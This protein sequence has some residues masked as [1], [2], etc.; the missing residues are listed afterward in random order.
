MKILTT[1]VL[2]LLTT[3]LH[4]ENNMTPI[5]KAYEAALK[6]Q[7]KAGRFLSQSALKRPHFRVS[8][9]AQIKS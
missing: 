1:A 5:D 4:A 3:L 6:D 2:I 7:T 8:L 9:A